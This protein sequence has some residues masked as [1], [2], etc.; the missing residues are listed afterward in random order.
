M[1]CVSN[2]TYEKYAE[3]GNNELV[4]SSG[5]PQL[6]QF[7]HSITAEAQFREASHFLRSTLPSI[8]HSLELWANAK[9]TI[10]QKAPTVL[11]V[12]IYRIL[13][14]VIKEVRCLPSLYRD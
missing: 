3:K 7:C 9:L 5:I 11:D 1:F 8:I 10:H 2:T 13:T 12:G 4:Q 6:R 14:D